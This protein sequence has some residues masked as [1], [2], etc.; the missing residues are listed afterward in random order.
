MPYQLINDNYLLR[1]LEGVSESTDLKNKT[2]SE[3]I[4]ETVNSADCSQ[5]LTEL[6]IVVP[7]FKLVRRYKSQIVAKLKKPADSPKVVSFRDFTRKIFDKLL[8][9]RVISEAYSLT[10]FDEA[11]KN[12]ELGYFKYTGFGSSTSQSLKQLSTTISGLRKDGITSENILSRTIQPNETAEKTAQE[13]KSKINDFK[14]IEKSYEDLL[15]SDLCDE[16]GILLMLNKFLEQP[17]NFKLFKQVIFPAQLILFDQFS[18]F[19]IPECEFMQHLARTDAA[20]SCQIDFNE[21]TGPIL[22]GLD[23]T[24]LKLSSYGYSIREIKSNPKNANPYVTFLN[25]NLFLLKPKMSSGSDIFN[26]VIKIAAERNPAEEVKMIGRLVK[27]LNLEENIS[28]SDI[29]I[30][31]RRPTDYVDLFREIFYRYDIPVNISDRSNL[32]SVSFVVSLF[33]MLDI[34]LNGYAYSDIKSAFS[35]TFYS[36]PDSEKPVDLANSFDFVAAKYRIEGGFENGGMYHW[37]SLIKIRDNYENPDFNFD[38]SQREKKFIVDRINE[39]LELLDF[40]NKLFDGFGNKITPDQFS[41]LIYNLLEHYRIEKKTRD[42]YN[43][44]KIKADNKKI[45]MIEAALDLDNIEKQAKAYNAVTQI[46]DEFVSILKER[47][48]ESK[49]LQFYVDGF[50]VAVAGKRYQIREKIDWG[51]TVTSIEQTRG[52]PY[53][54]MILCGMSDNRF[55]LAFHTDALLGKTLF[56]TETKH[57]IE[58]RLLFYK[59]LSN[60]GEELSSG[61]KK[62]FLTYPLFD[63]DGSNYPRSSYIDYILNIL[64]LPDVYSEKDSE[65]AADKK[66]YDMTSNLKFVDKFMQELK[67]SAASDAEYRQKIGRHAQTLTERTKKAKTVSAQNNLIF[68]QLMPTMKQNLMETANDPYSPTAL[69]SY[70]RCSE[71]Y[72]INYLLNIG[73]PEDKTESLNG[74]E[75]GNLIHKVLYH[76][77]SDFAHPKAIPGCELSTVNLEP[78]NS[79]FEEIIDLAEQEFNKLSIDNPFILLDRGS[80][81]GSGQFPGNL[82]F[83]LLNQFERIRNRSWRPSPGLFEYKIDEMPIEIDGKIYKFRGKID[84][85]EFYY[86]ETG[87]KLAVYIGDYKSNEASIKKDSLQLGLYLEMIVREMRNQK[88]VPDD[89]ELAPGGGFWYFYGN[90]RQ[91]RESLSNSDISYKIQFADAE[92]PPNDEYLNK[93]SKPQ[94]SETFLPENLKKAKNIID[95]ISN[96]IFAPTEKTCPEFCKLKS[97]CRKND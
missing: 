63:S 29:C 73:S 12:S 14:T 43:A 20:V 46:L 79:C 87:K 54:I 90:K 89:L 27:K 95:N 10:L 19:R 57:Y 9:V 94:L 66:I 38:I 50:R 7:T 45:S 33:S 44:L 1:H 35:A 83:F 41:D 93:R 92:F 71:Q 67:H 42:S 80:I 72:F 48:G 8:G 6:V 62:L 82:E 4:D 15:G 30:C 60:N 49:N 53:K 2:I 76:F 58:E 32:N 28:L 61:R 23:D 17:D 56:N 64:S 47:G 26:N 52:I 69:D 24:I 3:I 85:V 77:Y 37:K 40:I 55:P 34:F 36:D 75:K 74:K 21:K 16:S 18:N 11:I 70:Q 51:V 39:T 31:Y 96:G 68:N 86:D 78:D 22:S 88:L 91:A 13:P 81:I 5:K 25:N 97:I 59:F 84:R 65:K